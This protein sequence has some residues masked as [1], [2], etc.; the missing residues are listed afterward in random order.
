MPER[1]S[2][3]CLLY[4]SVTYVP[5]LQC[6]QVL[7]GQAMHVCVLL[8]SSSAGSRCLQHLWLPQTRGCLFRIRDLK[9]AHA[10]ATQILFKAG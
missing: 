9:H 10:H 2:I 3:V 6:T 4:V 7:C 8:L 5:W 1:D